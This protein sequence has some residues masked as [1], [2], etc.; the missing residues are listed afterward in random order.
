M[1]K[2]IKANPNVSELA[3]PKNKVSLVERQHFDYAFIYIPL[4]T[5]TFNK[6]WYNFTDNFKCSTLKWQTIYIKYL[7]HLNVIL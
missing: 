1:D 5:R 7:H 4:L 6:F 2:N 3:L